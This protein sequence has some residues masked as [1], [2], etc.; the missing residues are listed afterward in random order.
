MAEFHSNAVP[1]LPPATDEPATPSN[2]VI[3]RAGP[4]FTDDNHGG[5]VSE[6]SI[7]YINGMPYQDVKLANGL[8]VLPL[9]NQTILVNNG[10]GEANPVPLVDLLLTLGYP[11]PSR[12]S[13]TPRSAALVAA[14]A[15]GKEAADE[16][17]PKLDIPILPDN[18]DAMVEDAVEKGAEALAEAVKGVTPDVVDDVIDEAMELAEGVVRKE[19]EKLGFFKRRKKQED[20]VNNKISDFEETIFNHPGIKQ[21]VDSF[22]T[23][24]SSVTNAIRE[25]LPNHKFVVTSEK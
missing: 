22:R 7:P 3:M 6:L 5:R 1:V 10:N 25:V 23:V 18:V 24:A 2:P 21:G 15:K 8:H 17:E 14:N 13:I 9:K 4:Q 16:D 19:G 20:K 12:A 11:A